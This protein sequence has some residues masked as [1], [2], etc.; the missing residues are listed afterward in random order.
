MVIDGISG[1]SAFVVFIMSSSS[2]CFVLHCER[3]WS[4]KY[5]SVSNLKSKIYIAGWHA[6]GGKCENQGDNRAG[7]STVAIK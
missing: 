3:V 4:V 5:G 2:Q 7:K 6:K 1:I